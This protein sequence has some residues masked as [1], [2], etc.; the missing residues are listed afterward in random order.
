MF[1]FLD[2]FF[3]FQ[4]EERG[5][6]KR[7]TLDFGCQNAQKCIISRFHWAKFNKKNGAKAIV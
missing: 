6:K 7:R 4:E 3:N 5:E 1:T 2:E